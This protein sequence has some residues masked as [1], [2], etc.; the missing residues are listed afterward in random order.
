M[1]IDGNQIRFNNGER[2]IVKTNGNGKIR[3]FEKKKPIK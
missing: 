2:E 1:T 3:I